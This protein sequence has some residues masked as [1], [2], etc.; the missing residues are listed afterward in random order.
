MFHVVVAGG[1]GGGM[2]VE[3]AVVEQVDFREVK[4]LQQLLIQLVL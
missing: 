4:N 1:G 2:D 3:V